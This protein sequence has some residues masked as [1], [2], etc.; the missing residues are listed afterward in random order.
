[1]VS[2]AIVGIVAVSGTMF[3]ISSL[4]LVRTAANR[5]VAA[6]M[7]TRALDTARAAGGATVLASPPATATVQL[8]GV[9]F[10]E[11]WTVTLCRQAVAGGGCATVPAAPGT[12]ELAKV[13]V[14]VQWPEG[15]G[16]RTQQTAALLSAA[17][18][19]PRFL[20]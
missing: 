18:T 19:E 20:E 16:V 4:R 10:T 11:R 12:A 8:N 14:S 2:L 1:M 15:G 3:Q 6:Q 5:Q 9:T 17:A 7:V 13:V